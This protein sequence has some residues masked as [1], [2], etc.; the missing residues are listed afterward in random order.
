MTDRLEGMDSILLAQDL[1]YSLDNVV[2]IVSRL[3][4]GRPRNRGSISGKAKT[5]FSSPKRPDRLLGLTSLQLDNRDPSFGEKRSGLEAD[6]S[7]R[8]VLYLHSLID[9][10]A[11]T[12]T[13]FPLPLP[14]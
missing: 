2:G 5:F 4:A 6:H 10:M 14:G 3:Q 9:C 1:N 8:V 12:G 7:P 13:T 11:Y